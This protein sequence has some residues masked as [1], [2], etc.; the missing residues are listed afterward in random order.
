MSTRV[1]SGLHVSNAPYS[2]VSAEAQ[3]G[4]LTM[5]IDDLAITHVRLIIEAGPAVGTV[6]AAIATV[7][8]EAVVLVAATLALRATTV[9]GRPR[10]AEVAP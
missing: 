2:T 5:L 10:L 4:V 7:V 8:T 6:G 1:W 3:D 9:S